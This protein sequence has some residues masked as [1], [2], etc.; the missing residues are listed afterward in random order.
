MSML[1]DPPPTFTSARYSDG[2]SAAA[3]N[4]EVRLGAAGIEITVPGGDGVLWPYETLAA[5]EPITAHAIDVLLSS[6]AQPGAALFVP[7]AAFARRLPEHAPQL[8]AR[9]IRWRHARPWIWASA[10]IAAAAALVWVLDLSPANTIA[11]L[12]PDRA[13]ETLGKEVMRSMTAGKQV[14]SDGNGLAALDRL[15][16]RLAGPGQDKKFK[17][18]V[19]D[20]D[21]MNAFAV[22]GEQIVMTR[23]LIEKADGPDE[24]A[25]VLA[26][27]MGHGIEMHPETALVRVLGLSAAADLMLGGSG[28]TLANI[29]LVLAQL[30]YTRA[31][32][33]EADAHALAILKRAGVSAQ[34]LAQFFT[35]VTK[36]E[37]SKSELAE[38]GILRSHPLTEERRA[39]VESQAPYPSTPS[40]SARDWAALR[41]ICSEPKP[42]DI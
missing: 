23:G 14:C 18:V 41:S 21:L 24:V 36:L 35:R 33:R 2:R 13:R 42:T 26:H 8:T 15:T 17:I 28:G 11:R 29:G 22:P 6:A 31:A 3:V 37:E 25:G 39:I 10:A 1:S 16:T 4:A 19:V 27:E 30:S 40:L 5:A 38:I 9:S 32:E 12:L 20:W 34:G 7:E